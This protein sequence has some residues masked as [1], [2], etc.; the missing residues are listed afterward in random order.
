MAWDKAT[1]D[2]FKQVSKMGPQGRK[3][4]RMFGSMLAQAGANDKKKK[5]TVKK[6]Y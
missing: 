5:K 2:L 6:G 3:K 4:T 1:R